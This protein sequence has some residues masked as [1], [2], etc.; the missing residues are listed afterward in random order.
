MERNEAA[1]RA[2]GRRPYPAKTAP[3]GR[4]LPRQDGDGSV[5]ATSRT[6]TGGG[7]RCRS[8]MADYF[9][10]AAS[11]SNGAFT[12]ATALAAALA[13]QASNR[14]TSLFEN[15]FL[16]QTAAEAFSMRP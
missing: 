13:R 2:A 6:C 7:A 15:G 1:K 8:G 3:S 9:P 14:L 4:K 16:P 11:A 12:A 10:A 5:R